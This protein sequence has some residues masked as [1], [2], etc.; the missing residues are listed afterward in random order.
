VLAL[1]VI[2]LLQ[3]GMTLANTSSEVQNIAVGALLILAILLPGL[4]RRGRTALARRRGGEAS[5]A[6]HALAVDSKQ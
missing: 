5:R 4:V 3:N 1:F 2:G 6:E